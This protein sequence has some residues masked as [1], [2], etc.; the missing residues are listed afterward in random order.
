MT[1]TTAE[2]R[3]QILDALAAGADEIAVA[4][5]LLSEAYEHLD[6]QA[7]ERLEED[8]FQPVQMGYGRAKRVYAGFA[9]RY[10][11]PGHTFQTPSPV[12]P[13]SGT[14]GLIDTA[15]E[16]VGRADGMLGEL[17]DSMLP[18]EVGDVELRAG[19]AEVRELI[20]GVRSRARELVRV[21]GR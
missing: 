2:G 19:L 16:A 7:A 11:L 17:Q 14:K 5:A 4:L 9:Q 21:L 6:E 20:G 15:V 10:E 3:Q 13:S 8:L 12:A 1:Y 18:V